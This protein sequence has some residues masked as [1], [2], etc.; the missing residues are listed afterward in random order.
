MDRMRPQLWSQSAQNVDVAAEIMICDLLFKTLH[1][2]SS[3]FEVGIK[4][5]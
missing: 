2:G 4:S 1:L 5:F 3:P